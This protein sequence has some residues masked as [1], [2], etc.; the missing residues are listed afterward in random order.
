MLHAALFVFCLAV[1]ALG[2]GAYKLGM[3]LLVAAA[4]LLAGSLV[5]GFARLLGPIR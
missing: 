1:L 3:A 4:A 2:G 5:W